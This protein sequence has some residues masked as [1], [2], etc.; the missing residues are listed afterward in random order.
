MSYMNIAQRR[1]RCVVNRKDQSARGRCDEAWV[2]IMGAGIAETDFLSRQP[3]DKAPAAFERRGI[4]D[5]GLPEGYCPASSSSQAGRGASQG[6]AFGPRRLHRRMN[7]IAA[8]PS[9]QPI[10]LPSAYE[11]PS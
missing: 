11:R 10:F 8:T 3:V 1:C 4:R 5:H 9:F 6:R 2:R 7:Q